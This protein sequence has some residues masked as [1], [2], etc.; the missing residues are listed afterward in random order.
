[1][2]YRHKEDQCQFRPESNG[3]KM[4]VRFFFGFKDYEIEETMKYRGD[5]TNKKI[6]ENFR[7]W[8]LQNVSVEWNVIGEKRGST[9]RPETK[10]KEN[11]SLRAHAK[12]I[13][14][15]HDSTLRR[16]AK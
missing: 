10:E 1:M 5:I 16:I 15:K 12:K 7:H 8:L 3:H 9:Y 6:S 11:K 14:K 2:I 4:K 13:I